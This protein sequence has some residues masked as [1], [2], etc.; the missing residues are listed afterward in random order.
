MAALLWVHDQSA[1]M[2]EL[3]RRHDAPT[4]RAETAANEAR[5]AWVEAER[6]CR[7]LGRLEERQ[8]DRWQVDA[9]RAVVA[10]LDDMA[11]VRFR[12]G[13]GAP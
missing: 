8:R 3:I 9:D 7:A 2:A 1:R 11:T 6:R 4:A 13:Q 5:G 12:T 10:E